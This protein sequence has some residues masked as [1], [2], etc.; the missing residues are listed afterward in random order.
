MTTKPTD[1]DLDLTNQ[2]EETQA[3]EQILDDDPML[4]GLKEAEAEVEALNQEKSEAEQT[5][6][7]ATA[8]EKIDDA[9]GDNGKTPHMIPKPRFDEILSERDLIRAKLEFRERENEA[10]RLQ[11]SEKNNDPQNKQVEQVDD[12]GSLVDDI[13]AKIDTAEAKKLE[14]AEKYDD[15]DISTVELTKATLE[16]DKE[17]RGLSKLRLEQISQESRQVT[18]DILSK[19]QVEDYIHES[20]LNIQKEHPNVAQI[21]NL[22]PSTSKA[23]WETISQQA[24]QN[25]AMRGVNAQSNDPR[26]HVALMKEKALLTDQL[27]TEN[28]TK[29]LLGQ[30][31]FVNPSEYKPQTANGQ[32]TEPSKTQVSGNALSLSKKIELANSQPPSIASMSMGTDT[33]ELTEAQIE[34]MSQDDLAD[35][36]KNSPQLIQRV[37]GRT[38]I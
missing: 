33:G 22:P 23:V 34:Q 18:N 36:L 16:I 26:V 21:D 27:T 11:M 38:A 5:P 24:V 14:L 25:L 31:S 3:E 12:K 2:G 32:A 15:G 35:I 17:I 29:L 6:E 10:L 28:T 7:K 37:L 9:K 19:K 20:A 13:D 1:E 4:A 8:E 30:Y